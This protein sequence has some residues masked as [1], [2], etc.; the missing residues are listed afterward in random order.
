M[1]DLHERKEVIQKLRRYCNFSK[2]QRSILNTL[3]NQW[4]G[5]SGRVQFIYYGAKECDTP[6]LYIQEIIDDKKKVTEEQSTVLY[7]DGDE[8]TDV[9]AIQDILNSEDIDE[10]YIE[11]RVRDSRMCLLLPF[12]KDNPE[13]PTYISE[14]DSEKADRFLEYML[15]ESKVNKIKS[16]IDNA[17][18]NGDSKL[19]ERLSKKYAKLSKQLEEMKEKFPEE[20][21]LC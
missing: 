14:K 12:L 4:S 16:D 19:F 13:L 2:A 11:F 17:I 9:D 3:S 8:I 15:F 6:A 20:N 1:L 21:S 7:I 18:D 10:L 5:F